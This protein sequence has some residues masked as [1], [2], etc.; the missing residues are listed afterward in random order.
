M[1][2]HD[3]PPYKYLSG[4]MN[5]WNGI[6]KVFGEYPIGI[7]IYPKLKVPFSVEVVLCGHVYCLSSRADPLL[8]SEPALANFLP[9]SI[10]NL[11]L[12]S[13]LLV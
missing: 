11:R 8:K 2:A 1:S 3:R 13:S 12:I 4:N 7:D 9:F 6:T 5:E 10:L